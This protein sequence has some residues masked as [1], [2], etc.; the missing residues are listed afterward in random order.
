MFDSVFEN[1]VIGMAVA[2]TSHGRLLK[3]NS[4]LCQL[5]GRDASELLSG[6]P[7]QWVHPEDRGRFVSWMERA[8]FCSER[9][10]GTARHAT[11]RPFY[12]LSS[13]GLALAAIRR[14]VS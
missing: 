1:A 6:D 14:R 12:L 10:G 5:L 8:R 7:E 9:Y 13:Y 2:E 3:V 4:A 11:K